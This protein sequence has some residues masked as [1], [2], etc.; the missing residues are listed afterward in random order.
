MCGITGI[1]HFDDQRK[2]DQSILRKM[3]EKIRHRGPDG[4]GYFIAQNVGLGHR[5]LSIIDLSTGD[6]PMKDEND[7]VIIFNGEIYNYLEL[8]EELI[9]LGEKFRTTSDTE[10]ILKAYKVWGTN[11]Q[12]KF[13]GMWA[14]A[15]WDDAAKLLF[16]SRDR[17]GEKPLNYT[18]TDNSFIFS[19][20][21]KGI[22]G[23][24]LTSQPDPQL[25]EIYF[26]L[27]YIPAPYTLFKNI[28]KLK[29]GHY[30][31]VKGDSFSEKPYWTLPDITEADLITDEKY[32]YNE[33]E[34][35]FQNSVKIRMRSDVPFGAFLSGG[36][37]SG[38]IVSIMNNFSNNQIQTFTIGF[39]E[40][41]YDERYLAE[42]ISE[43]FGT[44]HHEKI[45]SRESLDS[46]LEKIIWH[47]DE[48]FSDPAAIPTG[49]LS[50]FAAKSV[51]MVLTGD[52]GDEVLSGYKSYRGEKFALMFQQL[53]HFLQNNLPAV[54]A[55][56]ATMIR[57][58]Y[59]YKINR[60][61]RIFTDANSDFTSRL[62]GKSPLPDCINVKDLLTE[63]HIN[64]R[65]LISQCTE[66]CK[67]NDPFYKLMHYQIQVSLP[68][69]MLVKV[70]KMSMAYSLET[71]LPFLDYRLVE[72][73]YQV[74]KSIKLPKFK[75]KN[76][77][78][79][80][81]GKKLP[82]EILQSPKKGFNVPLREWFKDDLFNDQL[83]SLN[84]SD[85]GLNNSIIKELIKS[86]KTGSNDCS[87]ILWR[88]MVYHKWLKSFKYL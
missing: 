77:L 11:C 60:I 38:S 52:G 73:M 84:T 49:H 71:R 67:L 51:K 25:L 24:G 34:K 57:G 65:D 35:L 2:V 29:A 5:R 56:M 44:N 72:L 46:T 88:I 75:L 15:L 28:R 55:N 41:E 81:V 63:D 69:R 70:D 50:E 62:L 42:I 8:R 83:N 19:S 43:R 82:T 16:I 64:V 47:Y 54:T 20:E 85:F 39:D 10:V 66:S 31:I 22:L 13:N 45:V 37:D 6:Q 9:K 53:P 32:V 33:F 3:T 76:V 36:L 86:H 68:D 79:K 21:I 80:T 12:Q 17:L 78:R 61:N 40:K 18:L 4:E 1:H 23:Y 58:S 26:N 7:N 14:F 27:G 87:M 59:R 48:P 30:I 74:H